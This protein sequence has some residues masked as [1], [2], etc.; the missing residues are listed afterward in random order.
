M[1]HIISVLIEGNNEQELISRINIVTDWYEKMLYGNNIIRIKEILLKN[2]PEI[3]YILFLATF[4]E[5]FSY[6]LI[7]P[8]YQFI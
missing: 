8:F 4:L 6:F 3:T 7:I 1:D 5:R 2:L